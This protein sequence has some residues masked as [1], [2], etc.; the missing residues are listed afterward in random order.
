MEDSDRWGPQ[1]HLALTDDSGVGRE[2]G[3]PMRS[4]GGGALAC[5]GPGCQALEAVTADNTLS[6]LEFVLFACPKSLFRHNVSHNKEWPG[7]L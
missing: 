1:R 4:L 6:A 5:L 2:E 7:C 3:G